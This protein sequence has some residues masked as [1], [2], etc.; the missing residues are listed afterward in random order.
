MDPRL[1]RP[2]PRFPIALECIEPAVEFTHAYTIASACMPEHVVAGAWAEGMSLWDPELNRG[3]LRNYNIFLPSGERLVSAPG[4][5]DFERITAWS[6]TVISALSTAVTALLQ[7]K[8]WKGTLTSPYLLLMR[9]R[10]IIALHIG[11]LQKNLYIPSPTASGHD[12][13]E[14]PV[15]LEQE[16]PGMFQLQ[17]VRGRSA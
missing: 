4:T 16:F 10:S 2:M 9:P 6:G 14:D 8:G 17:P 13:L 11:A 15:R 12:R 5:R 1:V 3:M 7:M